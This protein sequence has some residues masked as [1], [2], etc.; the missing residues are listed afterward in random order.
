MMRIRLGVIGLGRAAMQ[1]L[2]SLAAH[3]D[4]SIVACADPNPVARERF[5]AEYAG[6]AF[7][8]A[9]EM[10]ERGG[11][12]AGYVATPHQFHRDNVLTLCAYR[13]HAL[14][15]KPM[16]LAIADCRAMTD[17][18]R[19]AGVVLVVG[20][21]HGFDPVIV[22]MRRLIESGEFGALRMITDF[23]Y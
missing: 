8:S 9:E 10:C 15:E 4:I 7:G 17:A 13:K 3:P 14:V 11:I 12:D 18:A 20:P 6:A 1:M 23:A 22:S 5:V 2:P 16:A 21:T 19:R